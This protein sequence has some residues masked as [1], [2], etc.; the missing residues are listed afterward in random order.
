M[1][2]ILNKQILG[3]NIKRLDISAPL[4]AQKARPG[5]FVMIAPFARSE[6]IPLS[7]VKVS[8]EKGIITLIVQEIGETTQQLGN[9]P[10]N[11]PLFSMAGPL[12]KSFR[13]EKLGQ[14]VCVAT[15]IGAAQILPIAQSLKDAGNKV[16]GVLG[17]KTRRELFLEPQVR[18]AC[19]QLF[20][21]TEDGTYQQKATAS[22]LVKKI[23]GKEDIRL[24]YAV[25]SLDMMSEICQ[26]TKEKQ[27]PMLV[28]LDFPISC[29]T[30][31]CASCRIKVGGRW[32]LGCEE[33][34][35]FDGHQMDF[36]DL[37]KRRDA[38]EEFRTQHQPQEAMS[39]SKMFL[40]AWKK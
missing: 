39:L 11:E 1:F 18:P 29:P 9:M 22:I 32:V 23:L 27:I 25:G 8:P 13:P 10:L 40:E 15:G 12:G 38:W 37:Q 31:V 35:E 33:G 24:V 26:M 14:V 36:D 7:V 30:G 19:H 16:L 5:Q 34:P 20:V 17:A 28:Q 21:G 2:S 6:A 3:P 4:I